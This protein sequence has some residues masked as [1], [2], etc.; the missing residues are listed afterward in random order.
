MS[1]IVDKDS[2]IGGNDRDGREIAGKYFIT[3]SA[4][5]QYGYK[6]PE[7]PLD[8]QS[9]YDRV[10]CAPV[11]QAFCELGQRLDSAVPACIDRVARDC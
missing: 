2:K 1:A 4:I 3:S 7:L 5:L 11:V 6:R 8:P 10:G 9:R